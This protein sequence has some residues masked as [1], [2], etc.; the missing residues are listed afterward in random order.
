MS[1]NTE[2]L[3]ALLAAWLDEQ[4][5]PRTREELQRH[6]D[7]NPQQRKLLEELSTQRRALRASPREPAPPDLLE[8]VQGRLERAELFHAGEASLDLAGARATRWTQLRAVAAVLVL[9]GG[10]GAILYIVLPAS[11][12]HRHEVSLYHPQIEAG[13]DAAP[14]VPP[15]AD[16]SPAAA[17]VASNEAA[18]AKPAAMVAEAAVAPPGEHALDGVARGEGVDRLHAAATETGRETSDETLRRRALNE[19]APATPALLGAS[20][21]ARDIE[22]AIAAAGP[23]REA[24]GGVAA[25]GFDDVAGV[26]AEWEI[27][28]G[29]VATLPSQVADVLQRQKLVYRAGADNL[30][31]ELATFFA[32]GR[33]RGAEAP[34]QDEPLLVTQV[35]PDQEAQLRDAFRA[36]G[37]RVREVAP[38]DAALPQ[39]AAAPAALR[40]GLGRGLSDSARGQF[41]FGAAGEADPAASKTLFLRM[42]GAE[43][44]APPGRAGEAA[45]T[46]PATQ[47]ATRPHR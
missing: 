44:L 31:A 20:P 23:P 47:P 43:R 18:A 42:R 12:P 46:V 35:T 24:I 27:D 26:Q 25:V 39:A 19:P 38:A 30:G 5:D 16:A 28:A 7:A 11:N 40:Q 36:A 15:D 8:A 22:V 41:G 21:P 34:R 14:V 33:E 32:G 9:A 13:I 17:E 29:D 3:E 10:L 2:Q 1:R 4:L 37:L 6:L 45:T